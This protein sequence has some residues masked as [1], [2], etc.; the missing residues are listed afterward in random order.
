[1]E[2]THGRYQ[3]PQSYDMN[4]TLDKLNDF[5]GLFQSKGEF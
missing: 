3:L 5:G 1:M 4:R 2:Y